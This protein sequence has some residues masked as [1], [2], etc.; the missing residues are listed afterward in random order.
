[1]AWAPAERATARVPLQT[2]A[3]V[4]RSGRLGSMAYWPDPILRELASP[5]TDFGPE[6]ER[7]AGMLTMEMESRAIAAIQYGV[8]A[9]VLVLKGQSSPEP[10]GRP[11]VLVNPTVV[12]RSD[13][14]AMVPWRE[15]C[16]V[17]PPT[18]EVELLRDARRVGQRAVPGS[19]RRLGHPHAVR[20]AR[21]GLPARARSPARHFDRRP[22]GIRRAATEHEG[23]R[24]SQ[25]RREAAQSIRAE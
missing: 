24:G 23:G 4:A 9:Q 1:M 20:R 11:L 5:V 13:E 25:A 19:A 16:L 14:V 7:F 3:E 2:V 8:D 10:G 6:L 12:A 15:V 21:T 22:R 18:V 17:L